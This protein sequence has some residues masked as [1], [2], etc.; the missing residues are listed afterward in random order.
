MDKELMVIIRDFLTLYKLHVAALEKSNENSNKHLEWREK[1]FNRCN[2]RYENNT[3]Y[4]E[5][6]TNLAQLRVQEAKKNIINDVDFLA[7]VYIM[8]KKLIKT[9]VEK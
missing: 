1:E 8:L 3:E 7:K 2:K 5:V 4:R 6:T 9:E